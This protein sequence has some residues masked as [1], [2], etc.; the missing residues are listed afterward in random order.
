MH[1]SES[2]DNMARDAGLLSRIIDSDIFHSYRRQPVVIVASIVTM[3]M[4]LAALLAPWIAPQNPFNP[5]ELVLM[6]AFT[7]PMTEGMISGNL[8]LLGSDSQGRDVLS[9]ILYG[10]RISLLVGFAAVMFALVLGTLLGLYAGYRGGWP[11]AL[12]MRIADVQLT[13]PS[14][15]L[16]LLIFGVIRGFLPRELYQD[17]AIIVLVVSIGLSDWVQYAR[18]V[19]GATLVELNKEYIQAGRVI[20]LPAWQLLLRHLLPNVLR[21]VLVIGTIGLALAI[22]AEAT[23]SFLGVGMPPTQPSL[24]TLI[25]FG[26]DYMFSGE[27]WILLFPGLALLVL[28]LSVNLLG[29]WLRDV[30]NPKL[31]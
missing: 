30:L 18:A 8:Y 10:S 31:R 1:Y 4:L 13:F 16:A 27:W 17:A 6:D 20:G 22:I 7:P 29:D 28:A 14:I 19:R 2:G 5:A 15:L 23:L 21:P 25:R 24:G 9:A 26:Q 3:A 11:D 12:I